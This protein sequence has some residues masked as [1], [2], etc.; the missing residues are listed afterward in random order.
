[1]TASEKMEVETPDGPITLPTLIHFTE[2]RTVPM[3]DGSH[4][5]FDYGHEVMLTSAM[6]EASRGRGGESSLLRR[7]RNGDGVH[8]GP[9]PAERGSRLRPGSYDFL[10]ARE[11]ARQGAHQERDPEM[12]ALLLSKVNEDFGGVVTSRT[13][14][15]SEPVGE[16]G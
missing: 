11:R 13:L 15:T 3:G 2:C 9:W 12:R 7:I 16:D 6:V 10:D 8:A 5:I 14:T 1:M 4:A